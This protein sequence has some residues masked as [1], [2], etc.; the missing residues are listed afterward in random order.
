MDQQAVYMPGYSAGAAQP[1]RGVS[2]P[3]LATPPGPP[4][5]V[6]M[7]PPQGSKL[8]TYMNRRAPGPQPQG[9]QDVN[10]KMS[11]L[12]LM[13]RPAAPGRIQALVLSCHQIVIPFP[14]A[15]YPGP[16]QSY[17]RPP[18]PGYPGDQGRLSPSMRNLSGNFKTRHNLW[19]LTLLSGVNSG[20][21]LAPPAPLRTP[22]SASNVTSS[23]SVVTDPVAA[24][25]AAQVS[26]FSENGTTYFYHPEEQGSAQLS[27]GVVPGGSVLLPQWSAY[28]GTPANIVSMKVRNSAPNFVQ[29]K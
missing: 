7:A 15:S 25:A 24:A 28:S 4:P 9:Y 2:G 5:P 27:T 26:V 13:S 29:E 23:D 11:S 17:N 14:G 6:S 10:N 19:I 12:S 21:S 16:N 18:G 8:A 20:S 3:G 22:N 1:F